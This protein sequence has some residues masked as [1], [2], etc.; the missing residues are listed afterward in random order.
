MS[1]RPRA[2]QLVLWAYGWSAEDNPDVRIKLL[3]NARDEEITAAWIGPT[4]MVRIALIV[5]EIGC[6]EL[7]AQ[8]RPSRV[9]WRH[10]S[11]TLPAM[12]GAKPYCLSEHIPKPVPPDCIDPAEPLA[13]LKEGDLGGAFEAFGLLRTS[14][15]VDIYSDVANQM[16]QHFAN[17][18]FDR[19]PRLES[20]V[21]SLCEA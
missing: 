11:A 16:L 7:R 1:F 20:F 21:A 3:S 6:L 2:V 9:M 4:L 15:T 10:R 8:T 13:R 12:S 5:D 19:D 14:A 18:P 17:H